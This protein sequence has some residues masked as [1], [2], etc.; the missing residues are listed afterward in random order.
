MAEGDVSSWIAVISLVFG[1]GAAVVA[2]IVSWTKKMGSTEGKQSVTTTVIENTVK[3]L[4]GLK[5]DLEDIRREISK[6]NIQST[7]LEERLEYLK[8]RLDSL[9]S[10]IDRLMSRNQGP[11]V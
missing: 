4:E 10:K 1:I 5:V 2:G 11:P 9:C 8:E 6:G 3:Q 7:R